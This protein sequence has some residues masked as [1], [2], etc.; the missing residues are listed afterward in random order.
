MVYSP[1]KRADHDSAF[2]A[3]EIAELLNTTVQAKAVIAHSSVVHGTDRPSVDFPLFTTP[4]STGFIA[5]LDTLPLSNADT[6]SVNVVAYKVAGATQVSS[7]TLNDMNPSIAGLIGTSLADQ[8]VWSLDTAFFANTTTNGFSGLLSKPYKSQDT[9][10]SEI[11]QDD[12]IRAIY[13][14]NGAGGLGAPKADTVILPV[15][16]AEALS[17]TKVA[18]GWNTFA[19][20]LQSDGSSLE[21]LNVIVSDRVDPATKAWVLDSTKNRLVIRQG[22]QITR[23]Y[24]PQNDSWFI[25]AVSHYG[26]DTLNANSIVRV[27]DAP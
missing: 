7:E 1:N 27:W 18:T 6:A 17:L 10:G 23:T 21:G 16:A 19:L 8:T 2:L 4:V 22:T 5:E 26:W 12:L 15:A 14:V 25:S 11:T 9:N 3:P 24:I 13:A 20:P